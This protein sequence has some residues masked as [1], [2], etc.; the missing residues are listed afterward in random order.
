M[1]SRRLLTLFGALAMSAL[2]LAG[3]GD[4]GDD[5]MTGTTGNTGGTGNIAVTVGGGTTPTYSWAGGGV[6][7]VTVVRTADPVTPVWG[8][9]TP[10]A[11]NITSPAT[12]GTV[13]AGAVT[14]AMTENALTAG[15]EYRVT[16]SRINGTDFGYTDFTP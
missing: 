7:S 16:V 4:D 12:H 11:D 6:F 10:G 8:I 5:G 2:L 13:P 15:V 3:C 1:S 14:T 9:V